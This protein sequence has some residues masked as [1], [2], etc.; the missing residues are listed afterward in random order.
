MRDLAAQQS[1]KRD[2]DFR[3]YSLSQAPLLDGD[4]MKYKDGDEV[5]ATTS[6]APPSPWPPI[7]PEM[8]LGDGVTEWK[9]L[10]P[11]VCRERLY[12]RFEELANQ[13]A[14]GWKYHVANTDGIKEAWLRFKQYYDGICSYTEGLPNLLTK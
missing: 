8:L 14:T 10:S 1:Q 9:L 7:S 5:G 4:G 11:S 13:L 2:K 12:S 3:T 6:S